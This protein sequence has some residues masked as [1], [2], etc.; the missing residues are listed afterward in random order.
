MEGKTF[1]K[2][3]LSS[4]VL[5]LALKEKYDVN[6]ANQKAANLPLGFDANLLGAMSSP[7]TNFVET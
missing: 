6:F 1:F 7:V 5:I 3:K 4:D 2:L